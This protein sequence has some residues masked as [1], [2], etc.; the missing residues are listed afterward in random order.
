MN[1]LT[2][3]RTYM[4]RKSNMIAVKHGELPLHEKEK[5]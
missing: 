1:V 3:G 4:H 2:D 5:E